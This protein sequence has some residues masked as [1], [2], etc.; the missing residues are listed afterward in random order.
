MND[1]ILFLELICLVLL[2][3]AVNKLLQVRL[4]GIS[5]RQERCLYTSA[6]IF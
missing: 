6:K 5:N 4:L 2:L 1:L 3:V